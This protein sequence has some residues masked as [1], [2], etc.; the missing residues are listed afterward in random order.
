MDGNSYQGLILPLEPTIVYSAL[1]SIAAGV[2]ALAIRQQQIH[3][4]V[5]V[6][7]SK[8]SAVLDQVVATQTRLE[9]KASQVEDRIADEVE[10]RLEAL[11]ILNNRFDEALREGG[12]RLAHLV[13]MHE[14][15]DDFYFGT[16]L[17][18]KT[19]DLV[20]AEI[21]ATNELVRG[22]TTLSR[23]ATSASREATISIQMLSSILTDLLAK[24]IPNGSAR[25][26]G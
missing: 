14:H 17:T 20:R 25:K 21:A 5:A 6:Q 23:E 3:A 22:A 12:R 24:L 11:V 16:A 10:T 2:S 18:N 1:A 9:G 8:V 15:P 4:S 19:I 26:G 13:T 7:L